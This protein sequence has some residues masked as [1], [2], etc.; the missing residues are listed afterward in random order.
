MLSY[1]HVFPEGLD[2]FNNPCL[3]FFTSPSDSNSTSVSLGAFG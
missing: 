2:D 3:K 1:T